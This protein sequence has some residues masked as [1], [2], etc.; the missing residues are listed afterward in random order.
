MTLR[1]LLT[2]LIESGK[3]IFQEAISAEIAVFLCRFCTRWKTGK[4]WEG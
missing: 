4:Q 3:I 2:L 1:A